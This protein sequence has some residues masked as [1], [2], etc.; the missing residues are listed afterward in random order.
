MDL[1]AQ[2]LLHSPLI[3]PGTPPKVPQLLWKS[4]AWIV[5]PLPTALLPPSPSDFQDASRN[6]GCQLLTPHVSGR[7]RGSAGISS[8]NRG[9][10]QHKYFER[11]GRRG[12]GEQLWGGGRF[13]CHLH[14]GK[15]DVTSQPGV[16]LADSLGF[17]RILWRRHPELDLTPEVLLSKQGWNSK[18]LFLKYL[19]ISWFPPPAPSTDLSSQGFVPLAQLC[20]TINPSS[21]PASECLAQPEH[22]M[23]W[24]WMGKAG[25]NSLDSLGIS[26][27]AAAPSSF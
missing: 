6:P 13:C 17:T 14:D 7:E 16:T 24:P 10:I 19:E 3:L 4:N 5:P 23:P 22:E 11:D 1:G 21:G 2:S 9:T 26:A 15:S 27:F 8:V 20:S 12:D 18:S 25:N